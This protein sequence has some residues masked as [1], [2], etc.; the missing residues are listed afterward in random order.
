MTFMPGAAPFS[1]V[2]PGTN[3][4]ATRPETDL[5]GFK[6]QENIPVSND[7][8]HQ[9]Y[10]QSPKSFPGD[11]EVERHTA[12]K[13]CNKNRL[14]EWNRS[15][16]NIASTCKSDPQSPGLQKRFNSIGE[17]DLDALGEEHIEDA[18]EVVS[19]VDEADNSAEGGQTK[20]ASEQ[21]SE[22]KKKR[23]R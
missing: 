14:Q 10:L 15:D 18:A 11:K 8:G 1:T 17:N 23:F 6:S 7:L 2:G 16:P 21:S 9:E 22:K 5:S 20:P 4:E 13:T 3:G 12:G 19:T